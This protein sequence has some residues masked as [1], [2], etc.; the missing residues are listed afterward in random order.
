MTSCHPS[1]SFMGR[2]RLRKLTQYLFKNIGGEEERAGQQSCLSEMTAVGADVKGLAVSA[3]GSGKVGRRSLGLRSAGSCNWTPGTVNDHRLVDRRIS[4][5]SCHVAPA[6]HARSARN[7]ASTTQQ[8][9]GTRATPAGVK[10]VYQPLKT[11]HTQT[12]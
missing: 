5:C 1:L 8:R 3:P 2:K 6:G 4:G 9:G 10:C 7:Q 12:R 11:L